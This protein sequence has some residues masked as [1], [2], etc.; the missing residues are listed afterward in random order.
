MAH[1]MTIK[2]AQELL[3]TMPATGTKVTRK[4]FNWQ[5]VRG[6]DF[7]G[8]TNYCCHGP[9]GDRQKVEYRGIYLTV[10]GPDGVAQQESRTFN[11]GDDLAAGIE[12]MRLNVRKL[13]CHEHSREMGSQECRE[14]GIQHFGSCWHVYECLDCHEVY[15][16]DSSD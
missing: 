13:C 4:K 9:Y 3:N 6:T 1:E 15:S 5:D 10:W 2:E 14:K 7:S 8:C 16:V 11:P 12:E